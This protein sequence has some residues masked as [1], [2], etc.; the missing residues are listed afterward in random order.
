M[1]H[2]DEAELTH[3]LTR[4][5][6]RPFD[7]AH[8][9]LLRAHLFCLAEQE[10]VLLLVMH[11]IICDGFS[12]SVLFHE[13][14]TFYQAFDRGVPASLR[15]C[16]FSTPIRGVA[17]DL[18]ARWAVR[19]TTWLLESTIERTVAGAGVAV[20]PCTVGATIFP[21][22]AYRFALPGPLRE[23]L[24]QF[25]KR[26]AVALYPIVLAGFTAMLHRYT[27]L[28]DLLVGVPAANRSWAACGR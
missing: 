6:Q 28:E 12:M 11:H 4:E 23:A 8:G 21:R 26:E 24:R 17:T 1:V 15:S 22:C 10:A 14:R 18:V 7:L 13:L 5:T 27:A 9:P 20:R 2:L 3:R 16:R 19:K 25:S